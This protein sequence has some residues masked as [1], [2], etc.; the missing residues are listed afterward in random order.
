ME[1]QAKKGVVNTKRNSTAHSRYYEQMNERNTF[2]HIIA[3]APTV[4]AIPVLHCEN[5]KHWGCGLP[6]ETD[7]I[8]CCGV[9]GYMVGKKGYC[10]YGEKRG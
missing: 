4:E 5:C 7:S 1:E 10:V 2:K 6:M 8:K 9:G 3:A